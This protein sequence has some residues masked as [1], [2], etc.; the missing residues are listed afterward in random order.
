MART[1]CITCVPTAREDSSSCMLWSTYEFLAFYLPSILFYLTFAF[2][3]KVQV[4]DCKAWDY[5]GC[6]AKH[7]DTYLRR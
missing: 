7:A 5:E 3:S 2:I 4:T 1:I 6:T